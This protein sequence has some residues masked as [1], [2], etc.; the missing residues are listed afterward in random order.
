LNVRRVVATKPVN[1]LIAALLLLPFAAMAQAPPPPP[2]PATNA[3]PAAPPTPES[4]ANARLAA[5]QTQL[6]ITNAQMAQWDAFSQAMRQNAV[7]TDTLFRHRAEG[8]N[9]MSAVDNM[10]SYA[11]IAQSYADNT[12][13]LAQAFSSLYS[14]L[15]VQQK[16]TVDALFRQDAAKA[17]STQPTKP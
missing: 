5:L 17:A 16:Q 2:M 9:S 10:N 15:D 12:K 11:Q 1:V 3:P 13:A 4:A 7:S 14:V 6:R 8:V